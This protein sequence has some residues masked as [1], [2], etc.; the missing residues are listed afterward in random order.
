MA[1]VKEDT[2]E[3]K[4]PPSRRNWPAFIPIIVITIYITFHFTFIEYK[5]NKILVFSIESLENILQGG[6]LKGWVIGNYQLETEF[7]EMFLPFFSVIHTRGHFIFF[8]PSDNFEKGGASH[9][10]AIDDLI[11]P[12]AIGIAFTNSEDVIIY[13]TFQRQEIT[14][15]G[16]TFE[17]ERIITSHAYTE[18]ALAFAVKKLVTEITLADGTQIR[19]DLQRTIS[20]LYVNNNNKSLIFSTVGRGDSIQVKLP[21]ETEFEEYSSIIF[22]KD[23]GAFIEGVRLAE[24]E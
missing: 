16:I 5:G 19:F 7:G 1:S 12:K 14:I 4:S 22:R 11:L 15:A 20:D 13:F 18:Y 24:S 10:L 6:S 3:Q 2:N 21:G 23:R 9:N 17:T 8:V